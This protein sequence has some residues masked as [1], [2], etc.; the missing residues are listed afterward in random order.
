M[1]G[2][3]VTWT[4][5]VTPKTI[6]SYWPGKTASDGTSDNLQA[7]LIAAG[8]TEEEA[9][10]RTTCEVSSPDPAAVRGYTRLSEAII[11]VKN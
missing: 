1:A 11:P 5:D 3:P 6:F 2:T 10:R 4:V 9:Q 7:A 8:K